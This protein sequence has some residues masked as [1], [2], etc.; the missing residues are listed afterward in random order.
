MTRETLSRSQAR[1]V[2]LAAQ[3]FLDPVHTPATM[4]TLTRTLLRT[5]VLQIDS[6]NVLQRAQFMPLYSRMGPY[7][8]A[9]LARAAQRRPRRL[10]EYWAHVAAYMPV[11]LW[12]HM[13]HRM[14]RYREMDWRIRDEQPELIASVLAQVKERGAST[15]RDLDEGLP[16]SK[17]HWGWN[18]SEEQKALDY[19]F[20]VGELA[21]AGRNQQFERVFDLPERVIPTEILGQREPTDAE[22]HMELV[23]RAAV[24][25]GVAT[26]SCLRDYY[27]MHHSHSRPAMLALVESGELIPVRVEGWD[28]QAYLHRG[29]RLPRKVEARTLLSPFD[30]VVWER[31]RVLQLF[32]FHYRIEIYTPAP[33]RQFGYYVL[34]FLL[35][36]EL[37]GRVDLKADRK[38][39]VLVVKAAHAEEGAPDHTATELAAEL[40]RLAGW[41][42]LNAVRIEARG[43][44]SPELAMATGGPLLPVE[45]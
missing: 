22:A 33:K 25:H 13:Q 29:A 6:V 4:R 17:E 9:L 38:A 3:G 30:P 34:P 2:A 31:E 7:D 35:G 1:R 40:E 39:G 5:G 18:W 28:K 44:L 24:S 27:R 23:R 16:R 19:L 12:P 14:R 45:E 36:E 26:E 11:E 15:P 37:V 43:D 20:M 10:V 42:G 8:V 32:G 21:I 41:L